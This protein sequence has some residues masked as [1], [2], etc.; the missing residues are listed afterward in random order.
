M[1]VFCTDNETKET[2]L[3][4]KGAS[5]KVLERCEFVRINGKKE[6][7]T[8]AS[9]KAIL[10]EINHLATG[11]KTLRCLALAVVDAPGKLKAAE[12]TAKKSDGFVTLERG[13]GQC[14]LA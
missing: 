6:K 9:R 7:L 4:V 3:F 2:K 1:S 5:E 14:S 13:Y 10:T 8:P 11:E 12:A